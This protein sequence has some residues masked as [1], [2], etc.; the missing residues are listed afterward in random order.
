[1]PPN[2]A[3][4]VSTPWLT[5]AESAAYS[6]RGKNTVWQALAAG[7]LRGNQTGR[8]GKWLVHR[9]D[10]DAWIKGEI[11]EVR[12]PRHVTRRTGCPPQCSRPTGET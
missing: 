12:V 8:N 10:L 6:K 2:Q 4:A 11:A 3:L 7:E 1:M 5:L 9:D